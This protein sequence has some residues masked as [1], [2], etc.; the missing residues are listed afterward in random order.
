MVKRSTACGSSEDSTDVIL[1]DCLVSFDG[2]SDWTL[3]ECSSKSVDV[4]LCNIVE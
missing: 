3:I 1:E 2:N 4:I